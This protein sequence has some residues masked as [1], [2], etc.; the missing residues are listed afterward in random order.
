MSIDIFF[1]MIML[2]LGYLLGAIPFGYVIGMVWFQKNIQNFGSGNVGA[3]NVWRVFGAVPAILTFLLDFFKGGAMVLLCRDLL[4]F[5]NFESLLIGFMVVIG[6]CYSYQLHFKGGK[7]VATGFGLLLASTPFVG[8]VAMAI[9]LLV[10]LVSRLSSLA[11]LTAW[12]M[13]PILFYYFAFGDNGFG[14]TAF[15]VILALT[16]LI[17]I[18]HSKNILALLQGRESGF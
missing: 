14:Y 18:R 3:T 13:V 8:A 12:T 17:Y 6:H 10:F 9:W 4:H 1:L 11:G 5:S 2:F 7:G 15:L 16:I